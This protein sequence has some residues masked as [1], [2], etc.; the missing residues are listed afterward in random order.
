MPR[1][2]DMD[3]VGKPGKPLKQRR[4]PWR[5]WMFALLMT[6][7][8][9]AGGYYTW[10]YRQQALDNTSGYGECNKSLTKAQAEASDALQ[11][12]TDC[13]T[14]LDGTIHKSKDLETQLTQLSSNLSASK[15]ELVALRAGRSE[16]E[17]RFAAID[18]IQKQFA[19]MIDTGQLK[20]TSPRC[21][22]RPGSPSCRSR[23]SSPC[24]RSASR[25]SG[26][27]IAGSS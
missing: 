18:E 6:A 26:S 1:F 20:V 9:A 12:K 14:V 11:K 10:Q 3:D 27:P 24:S 22:S 8:A 25:S 2:D 19:K 23:A 7:G 13:I 5:L 21:C 16:A 17:K 4:F 15:D